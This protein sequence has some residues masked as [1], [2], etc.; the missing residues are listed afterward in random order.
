[1]QVGFNAGDGK[2]F[3]AV[4]A[5]RTPAILGINNMSNI[6]V[7][8]KFVFRIDMAEISNGGCNTRGMSI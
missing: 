3:Y 8:G 7:P 1:M 5:S 6:N 4:N 2:V